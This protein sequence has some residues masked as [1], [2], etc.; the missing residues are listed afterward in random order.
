MSKLR[1]RR[2]KREEILV[3]TVL[4][5]YI[6][7][8]KHKGI[9]VACAQ[10]Q[11]NMNDIL[12]HKDQT[13]VIVSAFIENRANRVIVLDRF[14]KRKIV[15]NHQAW[16]LVLFLQLKDIVQQTDV[17]RCLDKL[18][19][20]AQISIKRIRFLA[21]GENKDLSHVVSCVEKNILHKCG[22]ATGT[23]AKHK[24]NLRVNFDSVQ[25]ELMQPGR[26]PPIQIGFTQGH[27]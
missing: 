9:V 15:K 4:V 11:G 12:R 14:F 26:L 22:L 23:F 16:F 7:V 2:D 25:G 3:Q 27:V 19:W 13:H 18:E 6:I 24:E 8:P 10:R 1:R 17:K 5:F 20:D 21:P